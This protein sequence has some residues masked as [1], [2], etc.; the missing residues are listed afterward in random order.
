MVRTALLAIVA[1]AGLAC[2]AHAQLVI[3]GETIADAAIFEAAKK[4]GHAVIFST[5]APEGMKPVVEA[6]EKDT[7][8][9]LEVTRLPGP[10]MFQRVMTEFA[11]GKLEADWVD[12]TDISWTVQLVDH[13]VLTIKHKVPAFD[14]IPAETRDADGRWY[15]I[16]RPASVIGINLSRVKEADVPKTWKDLLDPKW[17]GMIGTPNIDSG[18]SMWTM[19]SFLR[20]K[21]DPDYWKKFAPNVPKQYPS[22]APV[23]IDLARGEIGIGLGPLAEQTFLQMRQGAP[24]RVVFPTEGISSFPGAGGITSTAKHPNATKLFVNWM[25]SRHGGN[26]IGKGGAYP[27]NS[28]ADPP[29][30]AGYKYP[31]VSQV[32]NLHMKDWTAGREGGMREWKETFA[33]KQ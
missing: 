2:S 25:T 7:G 15:S 19:Y 14:S 27:A 31:P 16:V 26:V 22:I 20:Q 9:K 3:D 12:V 21:V 4:E 28:L 30:V 13:G 1:T 5:Y 10:A 18:G 17:K 29:E 23:A 32:F 11:A 33:L 6:F 8:V 24:L